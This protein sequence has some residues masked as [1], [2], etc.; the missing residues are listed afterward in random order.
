MKTCSEH[1][2]DSAFFDDASDFLLRFQQFDL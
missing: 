1:V 2:A